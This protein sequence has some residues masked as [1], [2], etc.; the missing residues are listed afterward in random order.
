[1]KNEKLNNTLNEKE[2]KKATKPLGDEMLKDVTGGGLFIDEGREDD[3]DNEK[4]KNSS[5]KVGV[6]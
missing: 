5:G 4:K 6:R 1:M 3:S 2:E